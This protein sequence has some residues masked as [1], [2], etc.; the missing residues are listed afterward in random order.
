MNTGSTL[1]EK[2]PDTCEHLLQTLQSMVKIGS[3][4]QAKHA[5]RCLANMFDNKEELFDN[6]A[7]VS[8]SVNCSSVNFLVSVTQSVNSYL[9]YSVTSYSLLT[10]SCPPALP[11]EL[12]IE[13]A[14]L[15]TAL[16]ALGQMAVLAPKAEFVSVLKPLVQNVLVKQI[17]MQ[18][19]YAP[20][21]LVVGYLFVYIYRQRSEWVEGPPSCGLTTTW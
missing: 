11:G 20:S 18:D 3:P 6:L 15:C 13:S 10:F 9:S 19:Q 1:K 21:L 4:R 14:N 8:E 7:T 2:F 16:V 17:L 5:V 12:S